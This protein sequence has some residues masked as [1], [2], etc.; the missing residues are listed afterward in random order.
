VLRKN[1]IKMEATLKFNLP[2]ET[3]EFNTAVNASNYK[4]ALW[5]LNQYLRNKAKHSSDENEGEIA[6]EV[7]DELYRL[8]SENNVIID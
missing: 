4:N 6:Q 1:T 7:R 3:E 5:E 2:E 8:M